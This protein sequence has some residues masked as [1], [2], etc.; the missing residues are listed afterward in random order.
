MLY[1]VPQRRTEKSSKS[2]VILAIDSVN[3]KEN[4]INLVF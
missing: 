1:L 3:Y 4:Q 2:V